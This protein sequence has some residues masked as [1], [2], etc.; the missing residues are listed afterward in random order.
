VL[1]NDER[2][3][4]NRMAIR[5]NMGDYEGEKPWF[6]Y[7]GEEEG[8]GVNPPGSWRKEL[9]GIWDANVTRVLNHLSPRERF[10]GITVVLSIVVQCSFGVL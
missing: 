9:D 4:T 1:E 2:T 7:P 5:S 8:G 3:I 6:W 10:G